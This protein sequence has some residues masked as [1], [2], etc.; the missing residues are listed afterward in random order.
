[1]IFHIARRKGHGAGEG[2]GM[3][4]G[5]GV[6]NDFRRYLVQNAKNRFRGFL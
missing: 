6:F 1:M 5:V 3:L 4:R 2:V